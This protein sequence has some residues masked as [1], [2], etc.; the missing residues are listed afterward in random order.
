MAKAMA[1]E[2]E[3]MGGEIRLNSEV[4]SLKE[5]KD[6][7][8][9]KLKSGDIFKSNYLIACAGLQSDRI[10]KMMGVKIDFQIVP[11]RGDYFKLNKKFNKIVNHLIYPIPDPAYPFLGVHLTKM[12][13]GSVTVGPCLLYTSDAADE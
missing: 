3:S 12:I 1:K 6:Y 13:D 2:F 4:K 8:L 5:T 11:F 7:I 9:L 10:A